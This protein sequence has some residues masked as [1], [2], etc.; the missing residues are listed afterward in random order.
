MTNSSLIQPVTSLP[1]SDFSKHRLAFFNNMPENSIAFF[2]A[3]TEVT[4]SNDTEYAFCQNKNFYYLTGFNEPEALLVLIKDKQGESSSI[5][6][7]L[8]KNAMHEIW[9]GRRIGQM[10]AVRDYGFDESHVLD[11]IDNL[12]PELLQGKSQVLFSFDND[13]IVKQV[14]HWLTKVK[15]MVRQGATVP[16]NLADASPII[17]E[18]RL[19]KSESEIALNASC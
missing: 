1:L 8:A 18:L 16:T 13:I 4:R 17:S 7:S 11:E 3:N 19:I 10:K 5:L 15:A 14:F 2:S 9:H 6:F 12:V